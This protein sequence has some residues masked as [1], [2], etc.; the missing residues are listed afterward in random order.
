[1]DRA[2]DLVGTLW[3]HSLQGWLITLVEHSFKILKQRV[4]VLRHKSIRVVCMQHTLLG[5]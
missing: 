4:V 2:S 5:W 1:M 3:E